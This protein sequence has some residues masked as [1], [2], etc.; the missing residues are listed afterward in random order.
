MKKYQLF[1]GSILNPKNDES[2]EYIEH[3]ALLLSYSKKNQ[4]Y[5]YHIEKV[6]QASS[7]LKKLPK[8][9]DIF[10][11]EGGLILPSFFDMHF[12]WVQ[13]DVRTKPKKNLLDWLRLYTFPS[14]NKFKDVNYA[15]L[16]AKKFFQKLVNQGTLGGAV[17]GS[18]HDHTVDLSFENAVGHF[19]FGNVL[20]TMNSPRYLLQSYEVAVNGV[21]KLSKR[22][23]ENYALTP[24]FAIS[25]DPKTMKE[26]AKIAKKNKSFIQTHLSETK[27]EIKTVLEIYKKYEGFKKIKSYTEI[28]HKCDL[29]TSQTILGHGIHLSE[30]ELKILK[31]TR[32]SIAHCPTSNAPL[33]DLGLGSGLFDFKKIEKNKIPWALASDIGGGPFLSMFD[34][35]KSFVIQNKKKNRKVSYVKALYRSTLAGAKILKIDKYCGNFEKGKEANFIVVTK[36]RGSFKTSEQI[37]KKLLNVQRREDF[38][39]LVCETYYLGLKVSE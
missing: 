1:I 6:G 12:H 31:K 36:P 32:S 21:K 17:Y 33:K 9:L 16:K 35:M 19:K 15:R 18:I 3:G 25:T 29:L 4:G 24:R 34:V 14:E 22:Y 10:Y 2:C 38:E 28:Y 13:D 30:K 11:Y 20:M 26:T 39:K 27:E 7:I 8:D 23:K 5:G 37:L